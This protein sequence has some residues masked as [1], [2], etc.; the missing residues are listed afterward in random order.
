[1]KLVEKTTK[2]EN[3]IHFA[4]DTKL[5][6]H[7]TSCNTQNYCLFPIFLFNFVEFYKKRDRIIPLPIQIIRRVWCNYYKYKLMIIWINNL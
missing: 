4:E 1:M 2:D 5:Q 3:S 7:W 6:T